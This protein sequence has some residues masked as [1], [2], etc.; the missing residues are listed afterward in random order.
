[1]SSDTHLSASTVD[2]RTHRTLWFGCESLVT[3]HLYVETD[4]AMKERAL[5]KL[6]EQDDSLQC[7]RA[8]DTPIDFLKTL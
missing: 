1:M 7:Y 8:P 3:T 5:V 2:T 4:L 6:D